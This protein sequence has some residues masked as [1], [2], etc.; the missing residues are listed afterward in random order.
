MTLRVLI[1]DDEL[2]ARKR[3]AR[4]LGALD[5]VEVAAECVDGVQVLQMV[6]TIEVD[7]VLLD[8]HMPNLTG[9][10]A[11]ELLDGPAVIFTTAHAEH[12]IKAFDGGAVDYLLKPIEAGRLKLALDRVRERTRATAP[13]A[14]RLAVPTRKGV[15]M[16]SFA[17]ITHAVLDGESVVLHTIKGNYYLD[18]RLSDLEKRLPDGFLRVHRRGLVN[19]DRVE[20]FEVV[21]SGGYIAHI[22]GGARV[23]VSRQ[24]AR[25]LRKQWDL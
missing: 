19:L 18:I 7:V 6:A 12:A 20:R 16:L 1:A 15:V 25:A 23:A 3:L 2:M 4:L 5:G 13:Q 24:A 10:E 11:F 22:A 9:V 21:D 14:T 17:D 8:I